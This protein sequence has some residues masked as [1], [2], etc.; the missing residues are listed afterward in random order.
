VLEEALGTLD[1]RD[2]EALTAAMPGLRSLL[3]GLSGQSG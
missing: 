3:D 1:D 2:R